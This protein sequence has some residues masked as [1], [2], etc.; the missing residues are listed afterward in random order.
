MVLG[1]IQADHFILSG[2][3]HPEQGI[4]Q[5]EEHPG[6]CCRVSKTDQEIEALDQEQGAVPEEEPV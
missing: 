5:Y 1:E 3:P 6:H 4:H 2:N